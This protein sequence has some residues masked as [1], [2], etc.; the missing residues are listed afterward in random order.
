MSAF[1]ISDLI[2]VSILTTKIFFSPPSCRNFGGEFIRTC[3]VMPV[4]LPPA[5]VTGVKRIADSVPEGTK[6]KQT[7]EYNDRI[8]LM[9]G[10]DSCSIPNESALPFVWP[11][12]RM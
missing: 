12:H 4:G 6:K 3:I 5:G 11:G 2:L 7:G 9:A 1:L 10:S 8:I